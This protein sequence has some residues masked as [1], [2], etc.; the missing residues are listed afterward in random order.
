MP[1]A[2]FFSFFFFCGGGGWG[3]GIFKRKRT[4]ILLPVQGNLL[5]TAG[6]TGLRHKQKWMS[7]TL[8]LLYAGTPLMMVRMS[9]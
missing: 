2:F 7:F 3:G 4:T 1:F 6:V 8:V 5:W 9:Q